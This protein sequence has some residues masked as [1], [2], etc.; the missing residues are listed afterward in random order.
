MRPLRLWLL[1]A[2][3]GWHG[4][5]MGYYLRSLYIRRALIAVLVDVACAVLAAALSWLLVAP[6]FAA[7]D[8][9]LAAAAFCVLALFA[10]AYCD[11][12]RPSVLGSARLTHYAVMASMGMAFLAALGVYFFVHVPA[13]AIEAMAHAAAIFFPLLILSRAGFR[14]ASAKFAQRVLVIG[15]SELGVAIAEVLHE[16][17]NCGLDL[18]G[19]LSDDDD[20]RGTSISG[21]PVLG[22]VA[23]IEKVMVGHRIDRV[24]VASQRRDEDFPAEPLL[25]A[26]LHDKCIDSGLAFYE[27]TIGRIY[28]RNLRPSYLIFSDGFRLGTVTGLLKRAT[29]LVVAS[30]ALILATPLLLLISVAI[31]LESRGPVLYRQE[32]VGRNGRVFSLIKLRSMRD[33]AEEDTGA[34]LACR[35][36]ERI[37]RVGRILRMTRMDEL[38]QFWNVLVGDMSAVGPRPERPELMEAVTEQHPLFR[39]RTAVKPGITGW[40]QVRYGYVNE[41]EEFEHKLSLDL[42]YLKYRSFA[43]DLLI[44]WETVKTV[45]L[46]RGL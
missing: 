35:Q 20:L 15:A 7:L 3:L 29:D 37:T 38:P 6:P 26:K 24:V 43:F 44:L 11:A 25:A 9:S 30:V 42:F 34:V 2:E 16:R 27:R 12:Y 8:Y 28:L 5:A 33:G 10:L 22:R 45:L 14:W 13:G 17:P 39:W 41:L 46:F 21:Y 31:R 23:E 4:D 40:A 36:D 1:G 32:R 18:A 19:F